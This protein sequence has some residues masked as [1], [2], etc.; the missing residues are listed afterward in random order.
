MKPC[1]ARRS[2]VDDW[3]TNWSLPDICVKV[4]SKAGYC[5]SGKLVTY[6]LTL[7][8]TLA[9]VAMPRTA[10]ADA[11]KPASVKLQIAAR[12][13]GFFRLQVQH[14]AAGLTLARRDIERGYV[15]V[16]GRIAVFCGYQYARWLCRRFFCDWRPVPC[17]GG[18]GTAQSSR[19]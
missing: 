12:V 14:Q 6:A 4:R 9:S 16:P 11:P 7:A 10:R 2:A 19:N 13:A 1:V 5:C 8:M 15:D 3:A 17:S 18:A